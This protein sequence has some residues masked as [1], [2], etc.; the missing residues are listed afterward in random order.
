MVLY[1][2]VDGMNLRTLSVVGRQV[3]VKSLPPSPPFL[4]RGNNG[5]GD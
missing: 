2:L 1:C 4:M 3:E 5:L